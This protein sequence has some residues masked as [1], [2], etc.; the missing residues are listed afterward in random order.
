MYPYEIELPTLNASTEKLSPA[1]ALVSANVILRAGIFASGSYRDIALFMDFCTLIEASVLHERLICLP[2]ET[3]QNIKDFDILNL[4]IKEGVLWKLEFGNSNIVS[5]ASIS[6]LNYIPNTSPS[7]AHNIIKSVIRREQPTFNMNPVISAFNDMGIAQICRQAYPYIGMDR[8]SMMKD[9]LLYRFLRTISYLSVAN[10]LNT[11][12]FP[13][14]DRLA[15]VN[16]VLQHSVKNIE[17]NFVK[18]AND[19]IKKYVK[20]QE[21]RLSLA[22]RRIDLSLPPLVSVVLDRARKNGLRDAIIETRKEFNPIR[23]RFTKYSQLISSDECTMDES[24][25]ALDV[26]END[27]RTISE[28]AE[29]KSSLRMLEWRPIAT[30]IA[31]AIDDPKELSSAKSWADLAIKLLAMPVNA[32][33]SYIRR[34]RVQPILEVS[35]KVTRINHLSKLTSDLFSWQPSQSE[36]DGLKAYSALIDQH[37]NTSLN[38]PE[39]PNS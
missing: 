18:K 20:A 3:P 22:G 30:F 21:D 7:D 1:D 36:L 39:S 23:Q 16:P 4:L 38:K 13:N 33:Q 11:V 14:F 17:T 5:R 2:T 26:L 37:N 29:Q 24:L 27:L 31:S 8:Y 34:R 15:I 35:S 10:Q 6:L 32:L 25:K 12:Y 9:D 28:Y 19:E